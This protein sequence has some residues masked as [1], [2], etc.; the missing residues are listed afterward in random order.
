MRE[1]DLKKYKIRT[2]LI[3]DVISDKK[4]DGVEEIVKYVN[5]IKVSNIVLKKDNREIGR[6]KG[7]YTTIFFNDVTDGFNEKK[8]IE[9]LVSELRMFF[10]KMRI[11][12]NDKVLVVGLGNIKSTPDMLGPKVL[13]NIIVTSHIKKLV[14]SLERGYRDVSILTPG[15]MGT[16]GIETRDIIV[17]VIKEVKPDF[18]IVID[19]LASDK[20]DRVNKTIQITNTGINPG[21]GIG[22]NRKELSFETLNIPVIAI[23]VPTVV[24]AVTIVRDTINYMFKNFSYNLKN[25]NN[26][27]TKFIPNGTNNYLKEEVLELNNSEKEKLLGL[28]GTLNDD[29]LKR[30]LYEVLSPIG[31]NLMVTPK[32]IDFI[33]E[34]LINIIATGIN[35]SIHNLN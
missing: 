20:L 2:D 4:F 27:K 15:V 21:S 12:D 23:G 3:A 31:Y 13:D 24:D 9:V 25:L 1:I 30:L 17:G 32:E 28:V 5:D 22:N 11:K 14:G 8:I 35:K 6:K 33:M 29:E 7:L 10:N 16:T 19:S 18:L 26:P 34:K